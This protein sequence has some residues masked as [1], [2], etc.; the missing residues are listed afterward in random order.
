MTVAFNDS[1]YPQMRLNRLMIA[2]MHYGSARDS[3]ITYKTHATYDSDLSASAFDPDGVSSCRLFM[4]YT[5]MAMSQ[6]P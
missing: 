2:L 3:T 4:G 6:E 1:P 5:A